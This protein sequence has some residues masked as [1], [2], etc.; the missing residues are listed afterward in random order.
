MTNHRARTFASSASAVSAALLAASLLFCSVA[1]GQGKPT[2]LV[3]AVPANINTLD[4]HQTATATDLSVISDLYQ[5]LVTRDS[6]MKIKPAVARSWKAVN[7]TTW[8][9]ELVPGVT[10]PNGEKLDANTVKWNIERVLDPKTASR[11]KAWFDPIKEV[12]VV[13]PTVV[14]IV[15]KEPYPA[16]VDQ[17]SM[18]FLLPPKWA[19]ENNPSRIALGSGPYALKEFVS[20]DRLVLEARKDYKGTDKPNFDRV[21]IRPIPEEAARVAAVMAGEV[22]MASG[23]LP[24]EL[25]RINASGK[26][27]A[28]WLPSTRMMF[29]KFNNLK[30][31]LKDNALLRQAINH[32]ID[33]DS[34]IKSVLAGTAKPSQC[35]V[36]TPD[37]FGFNAELKPYAYDPKL[38]RELIAKSGYNP[39]QVLELEVP[40]GR[41]AQSQEIAQAVAAQLVEVGL[42]VKLVE[43]EFGAWLN[44]YRKLGNLGQMAY[45]GQSWQTLDA[46][47]VMTLFEPG[48]EYAMW[49]DAKFGVLIREARS[50]VDPVK[51]KGLYKLATDVMC[52]EAPVAFLWA[53]P[54]TYVLSNR[55]VWKARGDEWVRA[56]DMRPR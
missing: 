31:P 20:G 1:W 23:I 44:K 46:D 14:E 36:L 5:S 37:Y 27:K 53:Q 41:Y 4:P 55:I 33:K 51:R 7:D 32:A 49:S 50:S 10:F 17:M 26:A 39:S 18:F 45:M 19:T 28:A 25:P 11:I 30:A 43:M 48:N 3:I 2:Q 56:S 42:K 12:R 54:F 52:K 35:Q 29:V 47:G 21:V 15:T 38:A 8:Q 24:T 13:L 6:D 22:D 34:I 40:L 16:L 9:F